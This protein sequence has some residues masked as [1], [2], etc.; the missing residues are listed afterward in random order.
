[1]FVM[2]GETAYVVALNVAERRNDGEVSLNVEYYHANYANIA[3]KASMFLDKVK[4]F[5]GE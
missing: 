5:K 4:E 3:V 1:M 2:K